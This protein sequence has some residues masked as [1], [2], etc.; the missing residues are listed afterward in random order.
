MRSDDYLDA[1]FCEDCVEGMRRRLP[2]AC[3]D[4]IVTS[5]PYNIGIAYNTYRDN[6]PFDENPPRSE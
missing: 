1:V 3:I 4:V 2:D 5:P 6:L